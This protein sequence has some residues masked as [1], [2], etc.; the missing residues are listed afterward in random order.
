MKAGL[1]LAVL[2]SSVAFAANTVELVSGKGK[3]IV[4]QTHALH[5]SLMQS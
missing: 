4:N 5:P 1:L 3:L 2:F